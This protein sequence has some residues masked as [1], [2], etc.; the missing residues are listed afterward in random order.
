MEKDWIYLFKQTGFNDIE[1]RMPQQSIFENNPIPDFQ[2]SEY[3]EPELYT[4]M[5]QH[6]NIMVKYEEI[7]SYRIFSCTK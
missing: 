1:I 7:L 3:I 4:V 5:Y 6:F 2:Y